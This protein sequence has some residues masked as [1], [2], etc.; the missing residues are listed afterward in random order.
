MGTTTHAL[1]VGLLICLAGCATGAQKQVQRAGALMTE[2]RTQVKACVTTIR[3]RPEYTSLL[4]HLPDPNTNQFT[5]AQLTDEKLP[6]PR[7]ARLMASRYDE[8]G[9]CR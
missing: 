7:E 9:T 1:A 5:M 6:S 2:A 8:M 3:A 4:P